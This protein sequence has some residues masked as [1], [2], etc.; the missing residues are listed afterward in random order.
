LFNNKKA[1]LKDDLLG[2]LFFDE[3]WKQN[4]KSKNGNMAF[5]CI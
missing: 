4:R 3:I 1:P 2:G 5:L